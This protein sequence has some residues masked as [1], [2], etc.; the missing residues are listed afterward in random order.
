MAKIKHTA[1]KVML[2]SEAKATIV[3][4]VTAQGESTAK[5]KSSR[6]I[7]SLITEWK[8]VHADLKKRTAIVCAKIVVHALRYGDVTKADK[9]VD[10]CGE[11]GKTFIR[12]NVLREWFETYGPFTF[13]T[14]TKKFNKNKTKAEAMASK[15]KDDKATAKFYGEL[16]A[17]FKPWE[18]SKAEGAYKGYSVEKALA[19]VIRMAE[20]AQKEHHGDEKTDVV[21]LEEVK[22]ALVLI[23]E[24][25][26]GYKESIE[27]VAEPVEMKEAA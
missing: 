7:D 3:T 2:P 1:N 13:N 24:I 17:N 21:G 14:E 22:A 26:A 10:A 25:K 15:I 11:K 27:T 4:K 19:S 23:R 5:S 16:V 6:E 8:G 20:K 9:I 12:A 18:T